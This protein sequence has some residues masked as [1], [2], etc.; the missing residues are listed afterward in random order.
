[1]KGGI[2]WGVAF[3]LGC[4]L[5]GY[6]QGR[7]TIRVI[8]ALSE[9][10]ISGVRAFNQTDSAQATTN[11]QGFLEIP[12]T[13]GDF[14]I[15]TA[16]DY[17]TGMIVVPDRSKFQIRLDRVEE[18]LEFEGGM[19]AFYTQVGKTL[20]YPSAARS[21]Q[22]Q[23]LVLASFSIDQSGNMVDF[24]SLT[25]G[26][27]VFYREVE[28]ALSRLKGRWSSAYEGKRIILPV[29]FALGRDKPTFKLND[30]DISPDSRVLS[31]VIVMGYQK[32]R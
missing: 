17:D 12:A 11:S 30:K 5:T 4:S 13:E 31:E 8:D 14:V 7:V 20:R 23:G 28:R 6:S 10:P 21:R 29:L 24:E 3:F 25:P 26:N 15:L 9:Q 1:M 32:I 18:L 19:K 22:Q 2:P 16:I 27:T